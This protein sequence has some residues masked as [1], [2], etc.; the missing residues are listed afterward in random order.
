MK[1]L[2]IFVLLA[3]MSALL[4]TQGL[5]TASNVSLLI[6]LPLCQ[7]SGPR[8]S[9]ERGL[10]ILPGALQAVNDINNDSTILP[11]H[12]LQLIIKD[13]TDIVQHFIDLVFHHS[14]IHLNVAGISGILDPK[15]LSIL[16]PLVQH[17][18]VLL[19]AIT[20][21]DMPKISD[22]SS[23]FLSL[24]PPSSVVDVVLN[25]M[26][27]MNWQRI[28]LVTDSIHT[29]AYF[30]S[31]AETLLQRAKTNDNVTVSPYIELFQ[32]KSAIHEIKKLNTRVVFV[33][34]TPR[35]VMELLCLLHE[36]GILWPEYAWI[37][38]SFQ[39]KDLLNQQPEC[40]ITNVTDGIFLID[41]WPKLKSNPFQGKLNTFS[42]YQYLSSLSDAVAFE[43][44]STG[45]PLVNSYAALLYDL[46]WSMAITL[47][48]QST[49]WQTVG[50]SSAVQV[51]GS[52]LEQYAWI[53]N[54]SHVRGLQSILIS[55]MQ[56]SNSS[57]TVSSFNASILD[58]AP[59]DELPLV[60]VHPP[61]A[62]TVL[63]GLLIALTAVFVTVTL[64]FY[65][66]FHKE[67]E[68]K[69]TSFTLSLLVFVGCYLNLLYL[70]LLLYT[71][72]TLHSIDIPRDDALCLS[73][74]WLSATG[75]SLPLTLA[76]LLVKMLRIYHIFYSSKLHRLGPHCSDL[77]LALYVVLILM[78]GILLN[79]IWAFVDRYQVY[80]EY[81]MRDG[82]IYLEKHCHS[83]NQVLLY[84]VATMYLLVLIFALAVVAVVTRKVRLQNFKDTKKVNILLFIFCVA[85]AVSLSYWLLLQALNIKRYI[86]NIPLFIGHLFAVILYMCLLFVPKVLPPLWRHIKGYICDSIVPKR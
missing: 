45:R 29:D 20:H 64:L 17:K 33:S 42:N 49:L 15:A 79:L 72:H 54:V 4:V 31:V 25:F 77:S 81:K 51:L 2:I 43:Y 7:T 22:Y 26:R 12:N 62:Y 58:S 74:Q 53:F 44:N 34:V 9:W 80:F 73:L 61:F 21:K 24:P 75:I 27:I 52:H 41:G 48:N 10:E 67:P 13:D 1:M 83:K 37:F 55:T 23:D 70:G 47:N 66:Y 56:Y 11:G 3:S 65:I 46:V 19:S 35:R 30:F 28:G 16:L 6:S 39:I 84:G 50:S 59:K 36:K 40:D 38:H 78:P 69:A 60:T 82:Y 57:I 8:T 76:T 71:N 68:V 14:E 18:G 86:A 5:A 85:I 63:I 32:V